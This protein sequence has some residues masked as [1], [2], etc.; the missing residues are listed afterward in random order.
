M[1]CGACVLGSVMLMW[2]GCAGDDD[3]ADTGDATEESA[4]G[5]GGS[6]AGA[7]GAASAA[8]SGSTSSNTATATAEVPTELT[9]SGPIT[10]GKGTPFSASAADLEGAGYSE[11]EFFLEGGATAY[12]IDGEM[13]TDGKWTLNETTKAAFKTRL[14]VRRPTDESKFNG[15]VVVEWLN[16]SGGADGDPGFMYNADEIL[17]EGYAWVG[18]SAQAVGVQGGGFSLGGS[19]GATPLKTAD[20]ERYGSLNHPG[21]E[22]SFDIFS[23]A[24]EVIREAKDVDVLEGLSPERLIAYGES[25]SAMRLVSYVN[26]VHPLV[27]RFDGFFIHSRAAGGTP[28]GSSGG[29]PIGFGG[30]AA[31]IRDDIE[32][33][34]FQFQTETDVTGMLAF[35]PARQPDSDRLRTWEVAGTAHADQ[36]LVDFNAKN[37]PEGG[38]VMCEGANAGPQPFVIRAALHGLDTWLRDGTAPAKGEI[39]ETNQ[40]GTQK[41]DAH[42][43]ALGGVRSPDVDVPISTLSGAPASGGAGGVWCFLFGS[44]T[45]FSA[46][47][48]AELYATHEEYVS[49]VKTSADQL[50][51]AGFLLEPEVA[52]IVAKAEAA[53]VP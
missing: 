49:Q 45:P 28:F 7:A 47:K 10:N 30:G 18:V 53:S 12:A 34:V 6:N 33:K 36:Y 14:L 50:R 41:T 27:H 37:R 42:G 8:G 23:R 52:A 17:R 51:E 25:Q 26:G 15:S 35:L 32:E 3:V 43:N 9:V 24:A 2:G 5:T 44:T 1:K 29:L 38:G 46:D 13:S 19:S 4:A 40:D 31:Q 16:V 22:Y 11:K 39:L 21:D 20:P 48:L